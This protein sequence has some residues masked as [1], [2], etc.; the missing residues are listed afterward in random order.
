MG[1]PDRNVLKVL[2]QKNFDLTEENRALRREVERLWAVIRDISKFRCYSE[3]TNDEIYSLI[4]DV[5]TT[6]MEA[7]HSQDGSLLLM[8]EDTEELVFVAVKGEGKEQLTGQRIPAEAGIAG[9]VATHREPVLVLDVKNDDRWLPDVDRWIGFQTSSLMCIPLEFGG[10]VLG[11]IEVVN[12][13]GDDPFDEA[14]LDIMILIARLSALVLFC[15]E[16]ASL[17]GS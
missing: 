1:T 5:L 11:V 2:K 12:S 13:F 16:K 10:R 7:V 4:L 9:W 3:I 14:D 15:A 6:A 17:V 8:D